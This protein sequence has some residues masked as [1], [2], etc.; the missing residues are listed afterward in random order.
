MMNLKTEN[1]NSWEWNIPVGDLH[2]YVY[3]A[4]DEDGDLVIMSLIQMSDGSIIDVQI[5]GISDDMETVTVST[6]T[7]FGWGEHVCFSYD[8]IRNAYLHYLMGE[9]A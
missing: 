6:A 2:G 8:S 4:D 1:L 3:V 5:I 9:P 7:R